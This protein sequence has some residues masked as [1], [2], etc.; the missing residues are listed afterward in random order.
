MNITV[1]RS[2]RKTLSLELTRDGRLVVRAPLTM[3]ESRIATI[4]REKQDW[5]ARTARKIAQ[6]NSANPLPVFTTQQM[7]AL[8]QDAEADMIPRVTQFAE[9][10]GVSCQKIGFGFQKTRW[11]SCS[12]AG[13]L[14]FNCLLM[15]SPPKIRDYVVVH[16]LCHRKH[17]NHSAPFWQ[18]V[19]RVYPDYRTARR[20]LRENG[21]ALISRLP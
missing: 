5:I 2:R 13:N 18:E 6:S 14:R 10:L 19:A 17:M 4:I 15:C 3:P 9:Q 11:G 20:W 1:L 16:E 12:A 21:A 7:Q 8:W